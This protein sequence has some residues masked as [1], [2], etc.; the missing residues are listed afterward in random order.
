MAWLLW[1]RYSA[2]VAVCQQDRLG[3]T[4]D[5]LDGLVIADAVQALAEGHCL[6]DTNVLV[7]VGLANE[8]AGG[9]GL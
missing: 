9:E 6:D 7:A 2:R 3:A 1:W 4:D 5:R 8:D